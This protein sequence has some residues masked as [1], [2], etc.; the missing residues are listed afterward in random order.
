[1]RLAEWSGPIAA[2]SLQDVHYADQREGVEYALA[3]K[4]RT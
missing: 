2:S 1:M 3:L 4:Y